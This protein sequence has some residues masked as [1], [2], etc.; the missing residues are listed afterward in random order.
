MTPAKS[1]N[2]LTPVADRSRVERKAL[3]IDLLRELAISLTAMAESMERAPI[4]SAD[5]LAIQLHGAQATSAVW[6]RRV[7]EYLH[8]WEVE[9]FELRRALPPD[10]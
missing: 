4:S 8:R 5:W 1:N 3:A 9:D 6:Q 10:I 2:I 7:A